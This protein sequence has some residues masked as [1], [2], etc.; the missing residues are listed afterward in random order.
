MPVDEGLLVTVTLVA[1]D[2]APLL[3]NWKTQ[4]ALSF[5]KMLEMRG[6]SFQILVTL[7][8]VPPTDAT[9]VGDTELMDAAPPKNITGCKDCCE[10]MFEL[11]RVL[12]SCDVN[13]LHT[14]PV[15]T[16]I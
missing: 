13:I 8:A 7:T 16:L 14:N 9:C 11:A 5:A 2:D 6:V 12:G 15:P 10:L 4:N 3:M 1:F